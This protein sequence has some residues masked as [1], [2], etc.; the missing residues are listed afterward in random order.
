MLDGVDEEVCRLFSSRRVQIEGRLAAMVAAYTD[1]HRAAPSEWVTAKMSR[2]AT[3]ETRT[4]KER[5]ET[6]VEALARWEAEIRGRLGR[7]L[8]EV[9]GQAMAAGADGTD[10][11]AIGDQE[12]LAQAVAT[13]DAERSTW[14]RYD[15]AR[16]LTL[17][18]HVDAGSDAGAL[19]GRVDALVDQATGPAARDLQ[20]VDLSPPAVFSTPTGLRRGGDGGVYERHG[21]QRYSTDEG[22]ARELRI[23]AAARQGDGPI[24][25]AELVDAALAGHHQSLG[26]DQAAAARQVLCSGRRLEAL[27]GPAGTGKTHTMGAVARIWADSGGAVL[28][29]AVAETAARTLAAEADIGAVNTAKRSTNTESATR[30]AKPTRSGST[31]TRSRRGRWS[32]STRPGWRHAK[33]S[34]TCAPCANGTTPNCCWSATPSRW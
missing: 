19:L 33:S 5:T 26:A 9:W 15:L 23:L 6:T 8:S 32:S 30:S 22:L 24:R 27:V 11:E 7:S 10:T 25:D 20:V 34:T 2:W 12:A 17:T 1:R 31:P 29:L 18:V 14:T 28:G 4:A 3:V 13:V 21:A 16:Q